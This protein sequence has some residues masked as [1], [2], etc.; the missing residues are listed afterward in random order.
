MVFELTFDGGNGASREKEA[1]GSFRL[2]SV[3]DLLRVETILRVSFGIGYTNNEAEYKTLIYAL[4]YIIKE[5]TAQ[6]IIL[7]IVGDSELVRNQI[8]FIDHYAGWIEGNDDPIKKIPVW[9]DVWQVKKK[10]LLS[11]RDKARELL[12]QFKG[13]TYTHVPR[14][15][16]VAILGH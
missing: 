9:N 11:Y 5:Y 7:H 10:H 15:E 3:S 16:I 6:D 13:F 2:L 8:G 12:S 1:Y 4:E 14:K